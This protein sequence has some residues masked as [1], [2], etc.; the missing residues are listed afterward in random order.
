MTTPSGSGPLTAEHLFDPE[1]SDRWGWV[2]ETLASIEELKAGPALTKADRRDEAER[3]YRRLLDGLA[4]GVESTPPEHRHDSQSFRRWFTEAVLLWTLF[5]RTGSAPLVDT[6]GG[7][8][9]V[10]FP[11]D[12]PLD[13]DAVSRV[14]SALRAFGWSEEELGSIDAGI[15]HSVSNLELKRQLT[16]ALADRFHAGEGTG[17]ERCVE[18]MRGFYGD[19]PFVPGEVDVMI[20][21]TAL[22]FFVPRKGA[23]LDAP[24]WDARSA[25]EQAAVRDFFKRVD[26]ANTAQTSRFPA[27]GLYEP[28]SFSSMLVSGLAD[29]VGAR[30]DVVKETLATMFSVI[31]SSL[32][33]Q[34]LIHDLWGH[35]WQEALNEFEW[36]Y[37][38]VPKLDHPLA[39]GDGPE[40]GG[41][42]T[43]TLASAF[44]VVDGSVRLDEVRLREFVEGDLRGRIQVATSIPLS[45]VLAD[46]MESKFSRAK[47]DMELP[48]SSLIPSTSLKIDLTVADTRVQVQRYTRPYR[49]LA[50]DPDDRARLVRAL[51]ATGLPERGLSDAVELAARRM[52]REFEVAFDEGIRP[53]PGASAGTIRSSVLRR[54]LLQFTLLMVE[55]QR[56][57]DWV[58]PASAAR[59]PWKDPATCPDLFAIA[60]T[61]F[62][63]QDRQKNF[64]HIDQVARSELTRACA[65]LGEA[66][67][68]QA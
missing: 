17:P 13:E 48:T 65:R 41:D 59:E 26:V 66:I 11:L 18:L 60:F 40:L 63:E 64:W 7:G 8:S 12:L 15:R 20:T 47:P 23:A 55:F 29:A 5:A 28:A 54:L 36:E 45:E 56:A 67:S 3:A 6:I 51:V 19:L 22:F 25:E 42:G 35:T 50:V 57:L 31:P 9:N 53:E 24:T 21:S 44:I 1:L 61:H 16:A 39:P 30:A 34:Y 38:R 2:L 68:A 58:R 14:R 37:Q 4:N 62:Y 43:P 49:A 27:F 52:W 46:F 32:R 33:A 10:D